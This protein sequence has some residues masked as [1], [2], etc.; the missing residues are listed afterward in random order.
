MSGGV[1]SLLGVWPI[2]SAN[3]GRRPHRVQQEGPCVT[4]VCFVRRVV[5]RVLAESLVRGSCAEVLCT[6]CGMSC[7]RAA[8]Q[9]S[10]PKGLIIR[11]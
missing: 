7:G 10:R 6:V 1:S 5:V 11:V 8:L 9:Q 2:R 4:N 3:K